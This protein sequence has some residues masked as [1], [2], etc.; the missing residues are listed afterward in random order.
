M[1]LD[2]KYGMGNLF[3]IILKIGFVVLFL[4]LVFFIPILNMFEIYMNWFLGMIYISGIF[5]LGLIYQFINLFDS[6]MKNTPFCVNTVTSLRKGMVLSLIISFFVFLSL[7][8]IVF[9]YDYYTLG[10]RI[11]P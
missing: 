8:M 2:G 7:G 11:Y 4:L 9:C 6:L 1:K 5:F 3:K 10:V